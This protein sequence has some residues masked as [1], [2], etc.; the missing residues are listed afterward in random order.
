MSDNLRIQLHAERLVKFETRMDNHDKIYD[1]VKKDLKW[2]TKQIFLGMGGLA[3]IVF[4]I[5]LYFK[6]LNK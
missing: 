2:Q 1:E 3:V 4:G 5:E 6:F